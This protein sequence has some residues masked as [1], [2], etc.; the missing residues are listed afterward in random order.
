MA[1]AVRVRLAGR[2][3]RGAAPRDHRGRPRGGRQDRLADPAR[4]PRFEHPHQ[5]GSLGGGVAAH[6]VRAAGVHRAGDR[7]HDRRS[8]ALRAAGAAGRLRRCRDHGRRRVPDQPVPRAAHQHPHRSL[9]RIGG[10]P[11]AVPGRGRRPDQGRRRRRPAHHVPDVAGR[12]SRGRADLRGDHR[13]G[14]PD[15]PSTRDRSARRLPVR[16]RHSRRWVWSAAGR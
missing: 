5:S 6:R 11:A 3:R 13:P 12:I 7:D 8:R 4:G 1:V 16:P 9:G 15:G 2:D 14:Q 10:E